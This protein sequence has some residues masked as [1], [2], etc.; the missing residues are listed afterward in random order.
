[1]LVLSH[2][3]A[4]LIKPWTVHCAEFEVTALV[5]WQ[6]NWF[7]KR[8]KGFSIKDL[9]HFFTTVQPK[10]AKNK[11]CNKENCT[12]MAKTRCRWGLT[13]RLHLQ[14]HC[15]LSVNLSSQA[16]SIEVSSYSLRVVESPSS[17]A[18]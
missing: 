14:I 18:W 8:E 15:N 7:S 9:V 6:D 2:F 12:T 11:L 16:F 10:Q 5:S 17:P 13:F 3:F 1:M 4:D